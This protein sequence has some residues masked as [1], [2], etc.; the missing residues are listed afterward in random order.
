MVVLGLELHVNAVLATF[1]SRPLAALDP[2]TQDIDHPLADLLP[3][4]LD[5]RHVEMSDASVECG[6]QAPK[7][8]CR[9]ESPS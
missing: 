9:R 6:L 3:A 8:D 7:V 5:A 1:N 4:R 2:D